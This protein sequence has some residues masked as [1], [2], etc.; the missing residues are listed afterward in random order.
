MPFTPTALAPLAHVDS[1]VMGGVGPTGLVFSLWLS[2][3]SNPN[4]E[5]KLL[6]GHY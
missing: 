3:V 6:E 4:Q 2:F 1:A 5:V